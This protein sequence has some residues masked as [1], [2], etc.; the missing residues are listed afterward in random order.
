MSKKKSHDI[1]DADHENKLPAVRNAIRLA[2]EK[3]EW[4]D[5]HCAQDYQISEKQEE[6]ESEENSK[7]DQVYKSFARQIA[8]IKRLS[9]EEEYALGMRIKKSN[10]ADAKK[11]LILHNMRLALK[12]AHQYKRDW[13]SLMD[14]VQEASAGMAIAA[15]KWDPEMGTRFGT[16]AAYWIRAQLTKF[17]M[18][19]ARLIHTGNTRAGRKVY[20]SLPQVRRKLLLEGKKAT[21]EEIA[22]EVGEDPEEVQ[23]I[24][25]RLSNK[26]SSLSTPIDED[27]SNTLE[28]TLSHPTD[29]PL[30]QASNN[31]VEQMVKEVIA[32]FEKTINNERD[33]AIWREN[34][35]ANDPVNLVEL[36][37]RYGVS[38]QRM[39][40]L[41][42]RLKRAFRRHIIE[43]LG[44]QTQLSWLFRD[45]D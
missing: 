26:E 43:Q 14:L 30:K 41:A 8:R 34:L 16:Y 11:K 23:L 15:E 33:L 37:K 21:A 18:T 10:D 22:Q 39:G 28:D 35:I 24:L 4:L 1:I 36:G 13:A 3:G 19:N 31:E 38:K 25:S 5:E 20:F 40:Q 44:P 29:D 6:Q 27:G 17:L 9:D 45:D 42:T 12:M 32:S 2:D 7:S